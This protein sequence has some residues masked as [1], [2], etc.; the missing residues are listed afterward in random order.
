MYRRMKNRF[1][2]A[3]RIPVGKRVKVPCSIANSLCN[4]Q[5]V[6]VRTAWRGEC[7]KAR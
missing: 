7:G 2:M 5:E 1:S 6:A 4:S 3:P